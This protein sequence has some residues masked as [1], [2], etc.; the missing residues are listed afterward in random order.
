MRSD[1]WDPYHNT[2]GTLI[3]LEIDS[4]TRL[5]Y[6]PECGELFVIKEQPQYK[7]LDFTNKS[8]MDVGANIGSFIY[9]AKK[10]GAK[11][12]WAYEP[13]PSTYRILRMNVEALEDLNCRIMTKDL[14]LVGGTKQEVQFYLSKKYPSCHTTVPVRG[15][16]RITV[17]ADN[18]WDAVHDNRPDI[19]KIDVEGGE[20][21]FMFEDTMPPCVEQ[22]AIEL[23]MK[24]KKQIELA[25][26]VVHLFGD[27][28][29]HRKFKFNWHVTTMVAH[30]DKPSDFGLVKDIMP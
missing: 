5:F 28:H 8:V 24:N 14:A 6:R 30:R 3:N 7:A 17:E 4:K 27:W 23:H 2:D 19:I 13:T 25:K 1:S 11:I 22:I 15:R 29:C 12:I 16:D 9:L 20:Y 21:D 26:Q 18:F 10:G